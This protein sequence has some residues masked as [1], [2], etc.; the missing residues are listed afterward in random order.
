MKNL[1]YIMRYGILWLVLAF[2]LPA[3]AANIIVDVQGRGPNWAP[4]Y[5]RGTITEADLVGRPTA[6][7]GRLFFNVYAY[8]DGVKVWTAL[9][10]EILSGGMAIVC[11]T[12][13]DTKAYATQLINQYLSAGLFFRDSLT[14]PFDSV[15]MGTQISCRNTATGT[16]TQYN[17]GPDEIEG[18]IINPPFP[19]VTPSVCSLSNNVILSYSSSTLNVNGLSQSAYLGVSCT[20]GTAKDYTLRL[21]GSNVSGGRLSFGNNVSA[22]VYLNGTSV[23]ANGSGIRL[24]SLTSQGIS[25]RADLIGTAAT[26]GTTTANGV[27]ILDA[28]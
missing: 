26:S 21:T 19:P 18:E 12:N 7:S 14:V 17:F 11:N 8:K 4:I 22:Q 15:K 24:N 23:S 28:L 6:L 13:T 3:N 9:Q 5:I 2:N 1:N 20:N 27:L 25:V 10:Q 16:I